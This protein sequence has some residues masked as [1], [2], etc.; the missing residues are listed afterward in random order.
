MNLAN[1]ITL[2]R[3]FLLP[4]FLFFISEQMRYGPLIAAGIFI[5][6]A[7]TD[8]LDGYV[9]RKKKQVTT[10]GKLLDPL[11]DKLLVMSAL[12][13]LVEQAAL[14]AWIAIVILAR[15]FA[16]T[17]LRGVAAA[18]GKIIAA[19][20]FAKLKTVTQIVAIVAVM[21]NNY[22]FALIGFP[23][24]DIALALAVL[25][26]VLSALEYFRDAGTLLES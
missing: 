7:A 21:T 12:V 10:L 6:A 2:S 26:T 8:G 16:V 14:P 18:E 3:I 23:F 11:A 15:E 13:S 17:G 20:K 1:K 25:F 4:V 5:L 24:K 19:S 9:A 22:P